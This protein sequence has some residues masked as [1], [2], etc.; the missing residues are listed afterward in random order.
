MFYNL[1]SRYQPLPYGTHWMWPDVHWET[2]G[3]AFE[4]NTMLLLSDSMDRLLNPSIHSHWS[5]LAVQVWRNWLPLRCRCRLL[6]D[7]TQRSEK[8]TTSISFSCEGC[9]IENTKSRLSVFGFHCHMVDWLAYNPSCGQ[10]TYVGKYVN[11]NSELL[12]SISI[13]LRF[14]IKEAQ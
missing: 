11:L 3:P 4:Q 5:C 8:S 7:S 13:Y 9:H 10:S 1:F 14:A 12:I 6:E 2:P